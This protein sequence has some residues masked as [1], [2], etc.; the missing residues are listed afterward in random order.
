MSESGG[1]DDQGGP[2][3]DRGWTDELEFFVYKWRRHLHTCSLAHQEVGTRMLFR[4]NC[5]RLPLLVLSTISG[6]IGLI[7]ISYPR[8]EEPEEGSEVGSEHP[9]HFVVASGV[10]AM[11]V[12]IL[13]ALQSS[14][15]F[16]VRATTHLFHSRQLAKL[17]CGI[18]VSMV[19]PRNRRE[20][21]ASFIDRLVWSYSNLLESSPPIAGEPPVPEMHAGSWDSLDP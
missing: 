12:A 2:S 15:N 8:A 19:Q 14:L 7:E 13:T 3:D 4:H 9:H 18:E 6:S 16:E 10:M 20:P 17:A 5:I 1:S 21:S 11:C